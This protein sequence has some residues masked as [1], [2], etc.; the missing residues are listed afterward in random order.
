MKRYACGERF[1]HPLGFRLLCEV[2]IARD[3]VERLES[4]ANG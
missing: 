2:A 4:G 1:D 3:V